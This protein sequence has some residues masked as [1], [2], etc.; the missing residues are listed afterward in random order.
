[1]AADEGPREGLRAVRQAVLISPSFLYRF[2][3]PNAK[4]Q[5]DAYAIASRLSYLVW[6]TSPDLQLLVAARAGELSDATA[7]QSQLTRMLE[8]PRA[9]DGTVHFVSEWL[10]TSAQLS[11][12]DASITA[13]LSMPT[14]QSDLESEQRAFINEALLG[15]DGSLDSLLTARF[16][17]VSSNGARILGLPE[18]TS[19]TRVDLSDQPRRGI[20]TQPLLIAAHA[21]EAGYSVVQMGKFLREKLLCTQIPGPPPGTDTTL[22]PDASTAHLSYRERL[23]LKTQ[24][25][26]CA[27]CHRLMNPPGFAYLSF[28]P[29]G[30]ALSSDAAGKPLDTSGT[31]IELRSQR[32]RRHRA[33]RLQLAVVQRYD[34]AFVGL[35]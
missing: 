17:F 33:Q 3:T 12:K 6:G 30:C 8:S 22:P 34:T 32:G 15:S 13:G 28:D 18:V 2:E 23:T 4:G 16:N 27:S 26:P 19:L 20:L 9:Q 11:K 1:M 31:L 10:G 24:Q 35:R 29:I 5:L 21:K 7:R 25:E 14:L